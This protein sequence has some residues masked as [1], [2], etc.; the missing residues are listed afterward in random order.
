MDLL[1]N[2][3]VAYLLLVL[4]FSMAILSILTPGTGLLELGALLCL[5]LAGWS[6][7]N[8][9]VNLWALALLVLGV[10]PF[11]L[12]LRKSGQGIFLVIS[13]L[14]LVV[15]S[16]FLFQG[17]DGGFPGSPAVHP[18]LALVVSGLT[19]GFF[20]VAARK[21][22]E[23][24]LTRPTHDLNAL[25]GETGEVRTAINPESGEEGTVQVAGELWTAR[26]RSPLS[27]GTP[28][29][30]VARDGFVL[31]VEPGPPPNSEA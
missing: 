18:L 10:I 19:F 23:A 20:W 31:E 7:Y 16:I 25:I 27:P 24:E 13:L 9:P 2:P 3:N 14:A 26:S 12:A 4:G 6:V 8:L 15:G 30:I 5:L 29:R 1:L 11:M 28:V 22:L 21:T 17:E